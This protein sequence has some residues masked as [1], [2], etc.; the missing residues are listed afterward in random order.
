MCI[1]GTA[2]PRYKKSDNGRAEQKGLKNE[3][4]WKF[5]PL[6]ALKVCVYP[7]RAPE[8]YKERQRV[9]MEEAHRPVCVGVYL[10][11]CLGGIG[12]G[13]TCVCAIGEGGALSLSLSLFLSLYLSFF[14][15]IPHR[16]SPWREI[17]RAE[18]GK[19]VPG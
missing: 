9:G 15:S 12:G 13:C 5:R 8:M 6:G 2:V 16:K 3:I 19:I 4:K 11:V 10:Y 7:D 17:R 1:P 14:L 18:L